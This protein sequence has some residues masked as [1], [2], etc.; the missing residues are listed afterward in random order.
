[1]GKVL[2]MARLKGTLTV[3]IDAG[4]LPSPKRCTEFTVV[5]YLL[6]FSWKKNPQW[7]TAGNSGVEVI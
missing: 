4:N 2:R 1:M 7:L 3:L 6:S 5:P